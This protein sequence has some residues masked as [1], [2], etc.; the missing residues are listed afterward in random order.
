[1]TVRETAATG[2]SFFPHSCQPGCRRALTWMIAEFSLASAGCF[3]PDSEL[4]GGGWSWHKYGKAID[5]GCWWYDAED[6]ADGDRA[7]DYVMAHKEDYGLQQMIWGSDIVDIKDGYKVRRYRGKDHYDHIHIAFSYAASQNW[8]PDGSIP[9]P[10][11]DDDM[12][13]I[14]YWRGGPEIYLTDW[15]S[16]RKM[17]GPA[18]NDKL[19]EARA[20]IDAG[21]TDGAEPVEWPRAWVE[22]IPESR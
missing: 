8:M 19:K 10:P 20:I 11:E 3:N 4:S 1:M 2:F 5:L 22:S 14:I 7:W 21:V 15:L 18:K 6:K 17:A 16:R 13:R 9:L 12:K